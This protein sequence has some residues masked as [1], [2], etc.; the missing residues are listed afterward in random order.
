METAAEGS[1]TAEVASPLML[2]MIILD[3]IM[4]VLQLANMLNMGSPQN[5]KGCQ[6]IMSQSNNAPT[7]GWKQKRRGRGGEASS[8]YCWR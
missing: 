5:P 3:D 7:K 2:A 4:N 1:G 8:V 6:S